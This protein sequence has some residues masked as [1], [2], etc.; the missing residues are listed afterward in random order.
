MK[1]KTTSAELLLNENGFY[2]I[3]IRTGD[4]SEKI[5]T[6]V[7]R[8]R[9]IVEKLTSFIN[10]GEISDIHLLEILEDIIG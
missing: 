5:Y 9:E 1:N 8:D 2:D 3:V 7:S 4:T 10:K 6:E